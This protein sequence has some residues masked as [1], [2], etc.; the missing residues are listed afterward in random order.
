MKITPCLITLVCAA[1]ALSGCKTTEQQLMES[2]KTPLKQEALSDQFSRDRTIEWR[3]SRGNSGTAR[4]MAD[5]AASI[6]WESGSDVGKWRI[7]NDR[8]CQHWKNA[9]GGNEYCTKVFPV[10]DNAY[11]LISDDGALNSTWSFTN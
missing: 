7:A 5:G 2:G 1:S 9:R 6:Q 3:N 11:Q 8:L 4:Y 10:G